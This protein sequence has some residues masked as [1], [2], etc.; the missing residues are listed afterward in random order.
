MLSSIDAAEYFIVM[1]IVINNIVKN[2]V[3]KFQ[4]I[5]KQE[6]GQWTEI[7]KQQQMWQNFDEFAKI[8]PLTLQYI[9]SRDF[10]EIVLNNPGEDWTLEKVIKYKNN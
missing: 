6:P 7:A 3:N 10:Y 2:G 4:S 5:K 1:N 9:R 8:H